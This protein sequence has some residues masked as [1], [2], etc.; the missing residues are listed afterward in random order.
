[1]TLDQLAQLLQG[2]PV[3][4]R[5]ATYGTGNSP[6]AVFFTALHHNGSV[7]TART[8]TG[9][10]IVNG[11]YTYT[12]DTSGVT[13]FTAVWDEGDPNDYISEWVDA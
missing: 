11:L 8:T 3:L 10:T 2:T 9:V 1:M 5:D 12:Q 7:L 4:T 6:I 13:G